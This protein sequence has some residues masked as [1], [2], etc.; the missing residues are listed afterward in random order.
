[1]YKTGHD[2]NGLCLF[3]GR[4]FVLLVALIIL[5]YVNCFVHSIDEC[6]R[7]ISTIVNKCI[8]FVE[9]HLFMKRKT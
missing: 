7:D 5:A 6:V 2:L 9:K 4:I 8:Y 3:L 1:M